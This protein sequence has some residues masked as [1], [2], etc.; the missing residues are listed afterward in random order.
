MLDKPITGTVQQS[1]LST[2]EGYVTFT[3]DKRGLPHRLLQHM[4][5]Y[6]KRLRRDGAMLGL[7]VILSLGLGEP[8]LC[9]LH[10]QIWLPAAYSSFFAAQHQHM[11]HHMAGMAMDGDMSG[12]PMDMSMPMDMR[13]PIDMSLAVDS[14]VERVDARPPALPANSPC[15]TQSGG[16]DVPFHVPPSPVHE[17]LPALILVFL[18]IQRVYRYP[19]VPL[20]GPPSPD[21]G[22][23][24]R[25][26]ILRA[27]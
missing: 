15:F 4:R 10:C 21:L 12:M 27:I 20:G 14:T 3:R 2:T 7:L 19:L 24:L 25:P 22:A 8:L 18:I 11:H 5:A 23:L 17:L 26:P 13:M 16:A 6:L 9:I 1:Y